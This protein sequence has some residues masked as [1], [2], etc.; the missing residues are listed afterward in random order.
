MENKAKAPMAIGSMGEKVPMAQNDVGVEG[1]NI[2]A[3]AVPLKSLPKSLQP[4]YNDFEMIRSP[5]ITTEDKLS[6]VKIYGKNT[7]EWTLP[8]S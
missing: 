6:L 7:K 3:N 2:E 5:D 4:Y 8:R 1:G